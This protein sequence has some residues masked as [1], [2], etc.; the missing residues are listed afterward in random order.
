MPPVPPVP[1]G[2][3][4]RIVLEVNGGAGGTAADL[5]AMTSSAHELARC[6][7]ELAALAAR[8]AALAA[9]VDILA[10]APLDPSG[11]AT[12]QR[13]LLESVAGAR[14][15][16]RLAAEAAALGVAVEGAAV[17]YEEGERAAASVVSAVRDGAA[18][19]AGQLIWRTSWR[20]P[21]LVVPTALLVAQGVLL[22]RTSDLVA[23][24]VSDV[25]ADVGA[26]RLHLAGVDERVRLLGVQVAVR[27]WDDGLSAADGSLSWL[28]HRPYIAEHAV[29]ATPAFLSGV[30]GL[31]ALPAGPVPLRGREGRW[32]FP[33]EDVDDLA[34]LTAAV[35]YRTGT[36]RATPVRVTGAAGRAAPSPL[37]PRG[38]ADLLART[39]ALAPARDPVTRREGSRIRVE[40]VRSA[41]GSAAIVYV[42]GTQ[43]WGVGAGT[44]PMDV[45]SNVDAMAG[46][47]SAAQ[48]GVVRA[49]RA[50]GVQREEPLLLV[51]YSQGGLTSLNLVAEPAFTAE[52]SPLA[53][54]TAGSPVAGL[55]PPEDVAVL[56][57]EHTEDLVPVLD[58]AANPDRASWT[59][60]RRDVL[61]PV[62]GDPQVR[63]DFEQ[64][65]LAPHDPVGYVRTG[66]EVDLSGH[67]SLMAWREAAEPFLAAP[68]VTVSATEWVAT[69]THSS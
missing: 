55:A 27:L 56:S 11:W 28:A 50:A 38:V 40:R 15:L 6:A 17:A 47:P 18:G 36:F 41:R 5:D 54:V 66:R 60:V 8:L 45:T 24:A 35:G 9:D 2:R 64:R 53:V 52:F 37:P 13:R 65:P 69:R 19:T 26:G 10:T 63:A 48:E 58:G 21:L 62:E 44:N 30:T 14:G 34:A 39:A 43:S 33:P 57:L 59:T 4:S 7:A 31:R 3:E 68:G 1:T 29:A 46:L 12:A 67:P 49:L 23:E 25:A 32:R 42:P 61:D 16:G 51:G 22:W 20:Y